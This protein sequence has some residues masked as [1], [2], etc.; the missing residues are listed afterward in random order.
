[1]G[2]GHMPYGYYVENSIIKVDEIKADQ[3]RLLC[4]LYLEGKGLSAALKEAELNGSH[5]SAMKMMLN[6]RYLG[7]SLYPA[8]LDSDIQGRVIAERNRRESARNRVNTKRSVKEIA[9]PSTTF[10]I[11]DSDRKKFSDPLELAQYTYSLIKEV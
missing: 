9:P 2:R 8:I 10:R 3:V 1:M 11:E 4:R 5:T 6:R 7:D